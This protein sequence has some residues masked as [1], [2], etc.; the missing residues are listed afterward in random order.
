MDSFI[1]AQIVGLVALS[2]EV[3]RF[4]LK[5]PKAF[6]FIEPVLSALYA[7]QLYLLGA[8]AYLIS[9]ISVLRALSGAFLSQKQLTKLVIG[10]FIPAFII[11]GLLSVSSLFEA[12]PVL[13]LMFSTFAFLQ[14]ENT[15]LVRRLYIMNW[16]SWLFFMIPSGGYAFA[17]TAIFVMSSIVVSIFRYEEKYQNIL[18]Q[19]LR[20]KLKKLPV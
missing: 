19:F 3:T 1:W 14:R 5:S 16:M 17:I 18:Q 15:K 6:F 12:I 9:V 8:D 20:F 2:L 10:F 11:V 13:A 7:S 4:Q